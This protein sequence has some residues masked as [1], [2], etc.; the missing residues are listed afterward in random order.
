MNITY[1]WF[2]VA[3]EAEVAQRVFDF[4]DWN[5]Y[6]IANFTPFYVSEEQFINF[7]WWNPKIVS[8]YSNNSGES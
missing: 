5:S 8:E 4:D 7:W 2:G 1:N 3:N 6:T